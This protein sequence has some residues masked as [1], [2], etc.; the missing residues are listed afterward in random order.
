MLGDHDRSKQRVKTMYLTTDKTMNYGFLLFSKTKKKETF[1]NEAM[2]TQAYKEGLIVEI[3]MC[4]TAGQSTTAIKGRV[5]HIDRRNKKV[6]LIDDTKGK[7]KLCT[8]IPFTH[9]IDVKIIH[10]KQQ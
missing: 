8:P 6:L 2:I 7:T 3:T 1:H 9:I 10:T 4:V 5:F